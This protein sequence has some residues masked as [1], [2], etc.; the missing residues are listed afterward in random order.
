MHSKKHEAFNK[1]CAMSVSEG[2]M[3]VAGMKEYTFEHG[4]ETY[5]FSSKKKM[6]TFKEDIAQNLSKAGYFWAPT[7]KK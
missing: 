4:G 1:H 7:N 3:N 5:Y 6:Q 2:D